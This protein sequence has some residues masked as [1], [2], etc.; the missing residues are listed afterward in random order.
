MAL[1]ITYRKRIRSKKKFPEI[2]EEYRLKHRKHRYELVTEPKKESDRSF[3]DK[4]LALR[5]IVDC[6]KSSTHK[7]RTRL[8]LQ[9]YDLLLTKEQ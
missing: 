2:K 5:V 8:V 1:R 6:R 3:I 4:K 7:F 9:K